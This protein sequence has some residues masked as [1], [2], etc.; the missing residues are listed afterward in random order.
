MLHAT[1]LAMLVLSTPLAQTTDPGSGAK[2][3]TSSGCDFTDRGGGPIFWFGERDVEPGDSVE[4]RPQWTDRPG[5]LED[6]PP[7]CLADWQMSNSAIARLS[8]DNS[9]LTIDPEA[10]S[11]STVVVGAVL[12]GHRITGRIRVFRPDDQP[13]V[14][15]WTQRGEDCGKGRPIGELRFAANGEFSVTWTPFEVY[16]DYWGRWSHDRATGG[17]ELTEVRGNYVPSDVVPSGTA[18]VTDGRLAFEGLSLGSPR[19]GQACAAGFRSGPDR[20]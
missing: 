14:G 3:Q 9:L 11:G 5:L 15:V 2:H 6:I 7:G 16:R 10:P 18:V 1:A 13:F 19:Q 4:L 17:L 8:P 12:G 20:G